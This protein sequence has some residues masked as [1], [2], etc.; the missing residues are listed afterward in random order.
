[1]PKTSNHLKPQRLGVGGGL[2]VAVI[3][4]GY[5]WITEKKLETTV[6]GLA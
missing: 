6:K 4:R 1:M 3:Y 2:R 5:V